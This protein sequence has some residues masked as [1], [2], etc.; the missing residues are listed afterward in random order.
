MQ[1]DANFT[2]LLLIKEKF[3]ALFSYFNERTLRI[4]CAA[5]AK[6]YNKIFGEG[7]VTAVHRAT[8]I[9][10]TTIYAG[11]REIKSRKKINKDIIR[12]SGGGRKK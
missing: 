11:L 10:R 1:Q 2:S 3:D 5:E 4:W 7:G 8:D 12:K 6:N 9:S